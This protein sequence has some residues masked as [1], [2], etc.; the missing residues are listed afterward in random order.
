MGWGQVCDKSATGSLCWSYSVCRSLVTDRQ[1]VF[2]RAVSTY[3]ESLEK[4]VLP[5]S[6]PVYLNAHRLSWTRTCA[7]GIQY[8]SSQF[9][10]VKNFSTAAANWQD[11]E[12]IWAT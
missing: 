10:I 11:S 6:L 3:I 12:N 7:A 9:N 2:A 1:I 4:G 8:E 5:P